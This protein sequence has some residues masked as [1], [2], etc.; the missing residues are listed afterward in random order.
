MY[1]NKFF[2]VL[3]INNP[4]KLFDLFEYLNLKFYF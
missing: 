3:S 2:I 1:N 4:Q